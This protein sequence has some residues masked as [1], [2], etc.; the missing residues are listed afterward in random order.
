MTRAPI[1]SFATKRRSASDALSIVTGE[2]TRLLE[3]GVI[4]WRAPWNPDLALAATPGLPLRFT[5]QPYRGANVVLLWA[6]QITR[7]YTKRTWLSFRQAV[8]LGG[9]VRKG[10]KATPI[11]FYGQAKARED[12]AS[13]AAAGEAVSERTYRFLKLFHAFNVEQIE[14][15][16]AHV[17]VEMAPTARDP[18]FVEQW[19][20]RAGANVRIGGA[21][22]FYSP[23]TDAIHIPPIAAFLSEQHFAATLLHEGVHFTGAKSRLDRLADYHTDRKARAREEL[24][25]E[26]GSAMLGAMIGFK[27]DH[28]EDH[29]AYVADW[30]KLLRDEPKAFL[31]AAAKAQ[32]AID[33][34]TE[35]AGHPSG[36]D[37][38]PHTEL[39]SPASAV[40]EHHSA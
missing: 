28:L 40:V 21:T 12:A 5:G 14:E 2:L 6:A 23:V 27:P 32:N 20:V 31:S 26:I 29:A 19:L 17:G 4:P 16:P 8:Q 7:G 15:L 9:H 38:V 3:R 13:V 34:L 18:S 30:L 37:V 25:A 24:V 22:A 33:W 1:S 11:I 39:R 36:D 10:E 35:R